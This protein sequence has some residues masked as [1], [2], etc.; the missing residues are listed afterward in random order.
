LNAGTLNEAR[1]ILP[2]LEFCEFHWTPTE[3]KAQP[4]GLLEALITL[5]ANGMRL[6]TQTE[7]KKQGKF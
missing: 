2:I 4:A 5:K 1:R 3:I 7:N 6:K